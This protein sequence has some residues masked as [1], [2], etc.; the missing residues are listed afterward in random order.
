MEVGAQFNWNYSDSQITAQI[1]V[2]NTAYAGSGLTF[3]LA[4][5]DH[6]TNSGWFTGVGPGTSSQTQMKSSLRK[7]GA[8]ALNVYTVGWVA[9]LALSAI[10]H[11]NVKL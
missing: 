5:T 7:G 1:K 10:T 9:F 6:T 3:T 2:M 8:N 11:T 4:G